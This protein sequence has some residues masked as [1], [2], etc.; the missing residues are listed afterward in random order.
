MQIKNLVALLILS[1]GVSAF[2][3]EKVFFVEPKDGA[4]VTKTFHVK[5][6][7]EGRDVCEAEKEHK[8]KTCGHHHI[9]VDGKPIP[10]KNVVIKDATHLHFGKAQTEADIT[11]APGKHTLT[12][13][14]ADWAHLSF[15]ETL[16]QT[17]T[18]DV[19]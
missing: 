2:S 15:G 4:T 10:A 17:I 5:M 1:T 9:I 7:L 3:A 11:L 19:K 6:G 18:V 8:D 14:L 13:Q 16:S 12:L